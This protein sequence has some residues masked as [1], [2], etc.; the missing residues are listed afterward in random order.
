MPL[1]GKYEYLDAQRI[2]LTIDLLSRRVEARFPASG[3]SKV[4][5]RLHEVATRARERSDWIARPLIGLRVATAVIIGIIIVTTIVTVITFKPAGERVNLYEF[6]QVLEAFLN[7]VILIGIAIFFIITLETRFKRRRAVAAI[8][9]L[10]SI[11]HIIDMHQLT[12]DP[13]RLRAPGTPTEFSPAIGMSRFELGRY[14]DNCSEMLSLTGK[15][16]AL[17]V[18]RF[19]DSVAIQAV[20]DVEQLCTA[21]SS[22]I[23]QK[24]MVL[25]DP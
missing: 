11:A 24:I 18:Q 23:W 25:P 12:K 17:Y 13:D 21:L 14:L 10:R 5:R 22:K 9:E 4:C 3:L 6:I 8:H 16:A 15:V 7:D 1:S 19:D 20:N 2:V